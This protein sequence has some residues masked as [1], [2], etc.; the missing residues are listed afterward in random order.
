MIS[1]QLGLGGTSSAQLSQISSVTAQSG[2]AAVDEFDMLAQSRNTS[3]DTPT[4]SAPNNG[5]KSEVVSM[6]VSFGFPHSIFPF[7]EVYNW[8]EF[9]ILFGFGNWMSGIF[10][11]LVIILYR[12]MSSC[13]YLKFAC[14]ILFQIMITFEHINSCF[15]TWFISFLNFQNANESELDEM[16]AWLH[17]SVSI[18][19]PT[20]KLF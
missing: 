16:A 14:I 6:T 1:P 9:L 7:V 2:S 13:S 17:N 4:K 10:S 5:Q 18:N 3:S 12:N 20:I 11:Y 8:P 19:Y 15:C